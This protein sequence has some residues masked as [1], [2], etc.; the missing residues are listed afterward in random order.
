MIRPANEMLIHKFPIWLIFL[1]SVTIEQNT[2]L[3]LP[4]PKL[5]LDPIL[6][7][8]F[9]G[10]K[11][12]WEYQDKRIPSRHPLSSR[13]DLLTMNKRKPFFLEWHEI[14]FKMLECALIY[15]FLS[16]FFIQIM[17][18]L[19]PKLNHM[20]PFS[21]ANIPEFQF[22]WRNIRFVI[23][24]THSLLPGMIHPILF[25]YRCLNLLFA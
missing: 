25:D 3:S 6:I 24:L 13:K 21:H 18:Y 5:F 19:E 1:Y 20:N 22:H 2:C 17:I 10:H 14:R 16:D 8:M 11:L 4:K 12:W 15:E 9:P 23:S 7:G